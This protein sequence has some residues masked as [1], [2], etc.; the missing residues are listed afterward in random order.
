MGVNQPP[1]KADDPGNRSRF[2]VR[3]MLFLV[4]IA[5]VD[6]TWAPT[7]WRMKSTMGFGGGGNHILDP[8]VLGLGNVLT[9]GIYLWVSQRRRS[10]FLI[11][12]LGA[13]VLLLGAYAG[14]LWTKDFIRSYENTY[15]LIF[16][17]H[18]VAWVPVNE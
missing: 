1:P 13:G 5:A 18:F 8:P 16:Q 4:L 9:L 2:T 17:D 10:P 3:M 15:L 11:G 7:I 14:T 12:F 6:S